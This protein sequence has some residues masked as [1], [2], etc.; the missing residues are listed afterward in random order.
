MTPENQIILLIITDGKKWRY[1]A[2]KKLLALFRGI[3]SNNN[4]DFYCISSLHSFRTGTKI[5]GHENV[6]KNHDYYYIEI[7]KVHN[8]ILKYNQGE[9]P[10]KVPFVIYADTAWILFLKNR[11]LS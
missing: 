11:H 4:G 7:P 9:K 2:I 8:K 3:T 6:C 1:L 5:K 10:V